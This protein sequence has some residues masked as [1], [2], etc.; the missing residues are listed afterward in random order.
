MRWRGD[1][2]FSVGSMLKYITKATAEYPIR[3]LNHLGVTTNF[4]AHSFFVILSS[5]HGIVITIVSQFR[6]L[7]LPDN[8]RVDMN[9]IVRIP[10]KLRN[11]GGAKYKNGTGSSRKR[12]IAVS[13]L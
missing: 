11:R 7:K 12:L 9:P 8:I 4:L 1:I 3:L 10:D 6:K 2:K 13:I 5:S